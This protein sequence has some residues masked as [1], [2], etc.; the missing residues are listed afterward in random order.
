MKNTLFIGAVLGT[1]LSTA[2]YL[3]TQ[4]KSK[5]TMTKRIKS[6]VDELMK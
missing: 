3:T 5:N 2:L 6:A 4:E 1:V